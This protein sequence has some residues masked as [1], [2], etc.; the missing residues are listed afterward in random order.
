[1]IAT[2]PSPAQPK[3]SFSEYD[4]IVIGGQPHRYFQTR[5]EGH[6]FVAAKGTGVPQ[7]M[8]NAEISRYLAVGNFECTPNEYQPEHLRQRLLPD[9]DLLS[10][11]GTKAQ[12]KASMR[13]SVVKAFRELLNDETND[14]TR[15]A[16][17]VRPVL[18]YIRMRAGEIMEMEQREGDSDYLAV[19][20]KLGAK[21]VLEWERRER[22]F[23]LAGLYDKSAERG[24][25]DRRMTADELMLMGKV[26]GKY[27]SDQRPSQAIIFN[28]VKT[29]FL[30]ENERRRAEGEPEIV[31]PSRETV[32]QA[33]RKLNRFDMTLTRHGRQAA[34]RQF[35]PVGMGLQIE[36]PMQRVEFDEW[37]VDAITLMAE[38]GLF[39]HLTDEE[40]KKF[41]LDKKKARWWITVA[42]CCATRCIVGMVISRTPNSQSALRVIEMMMRDKGVWGDACGGLT[43]WNQFGWPSVIV[44]D[45]AAYNI[46]SLVQARTSDLGITVEYCPAGDPHLK[47]R[48]E[49]VFGTFATQLMPRLSGRTFSNSVKRGDYESDKRAVLT[50]EEFCTVLVRYVVDVYHRSPHSGLNGETPLDCWNRLVE[51]FGVQ[52]PPDL[53][54]RRL[55]FGQERERTATKQGI[56]ILGVRYHSEVLARFMTESEDRKVAIRWYPEDIGAIWVELNGRWYEIPAVFDRYQGGSAQEW[57]N[58]AAEIRAQN[59]QSAEVNFAVVRQALD[60]I[61]ETNSAA[62]TRVG[63][64][65][66]DWSEK[67]M[68]YEEDRLFIGFT[69]SETEPKNPYD[70]DRGSWGTSL[71]TAGSATSETSEP[72]NRDDAA[73][74]FSG[75]HRAIQFPDSQPGD[76]ADGADNSS[77]WSIE[78]K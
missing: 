12:R 20:K 40:K 49:R 15:I 56:T 42:I 75:G 44:T 43:P 48:I 27:L 36:R 26:V 68:D 19:P 5:E 28:E 45:C 55:I 52:P 34:N 29:A 60:Y 70:E 33:I 17:S 78:D 10:L 16:T 38:G 31:R 13:F 39:H 59:S 46:S 76:D 61:K 77:D 9:G 53:G 6:I 3:F 32:R 7:V 74:T 64:I 47:G 14:V 1:M 4:G 21:T 67:R 73:E 71:P 8:T 24:N 22:R 51:K 25:R 2:T 72:N 65:M 11:R 41:G 37:E 69:T 66:E 63:L 30:E 23:G 58:A 35:A 62:M 54:R 18:G 57:V 50:P